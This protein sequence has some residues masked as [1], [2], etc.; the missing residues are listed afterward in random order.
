MKRFATVFAIAF[1][2]VVPGILITQKIALATV[3]FV[4][5]QA[6]K[7][8]GDRALDAIWKLPEVQQKAEEIQR[9]SNGKVRVKL[10][11]ESEATRTWRDPRLLEEVGDLCTSPIRKALYFSRTVARETGDWGLVRAG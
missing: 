3:A 1:C 2:L 5:A 8:A 4:T 10:M 9:V 11:V 6:S 7:T